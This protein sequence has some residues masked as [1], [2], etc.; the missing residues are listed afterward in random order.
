MDSVD[1]QLKALEY[2]KDWS[3]YLLVT[4][5]AALGWVSTQEEAVLPSFSKTWCIWL[6]AVSILFAILTLALIPHVAEGVTKSDKSFYDV[7]P[8][9][10]VFWLWGPLPSARL[11]WVCW[12]QHMLFLLG[13][14]LYAYGTSRAPNV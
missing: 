8:K 4:T 12:P 10:H 1:Q 13:I 14:L 11:P 7:R 2:F 3:N 5:V 9:F 6:F